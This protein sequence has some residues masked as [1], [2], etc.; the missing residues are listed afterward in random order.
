MKIFI[1]YSRVDQPLVESL[2]NDLTK[3]GHEV[4]IDQNLLGG[5]AWWDEI[6]QRIRECQAYVFALS[7][8]SLDSEACMAELGYANALRR[9]LLPIMVAKTN[10]SYF[11]PEISHAQYVTYEPEGRETVMSLVASLSSLQVGGDLPNPLPDPPGIPESPLYELRVTINQDSEIPRS[12]QLWILD[13]LRRQLGNLQLQNDVTQMLEAFRR[14]PDIMADVATDLDQLKEDL[15]KIISQQQRDG[16][17]PIPIKK[18]KVGRFPRWAVIAAAVV[19]VGGGTGAGIALSSSGGSYPS[20]I[21]SRYLSGCEGNGG[22]N[23]YCQCTLNYL[24]AN[25]PLQTF[26]AWSTQ[27]NSNES[28]SDY[29]QGFKNAIS[30]CIQYQ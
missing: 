30:S 1:S 13:G 9:P 11:P 8:S 16:V 6:L 22:K 14:R 10:A 17:T 5:Q 3:L 26:I 25:V 19:V 7:P 27:I 24:E 23:T 28:E 2:K 15:A 4:W 29:P 20:N 21:A 18:N 12:R